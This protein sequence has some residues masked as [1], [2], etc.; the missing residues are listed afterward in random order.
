MRSLLIFIGISTLFAAIQVGAGRCVPGQSN[1]MLVRVAAEHR[2]HA[3]THVYG[4][5][6]NQGDSDNVI[7]K[8]NDVITEASPAVAS[9]AADR[10]FLGAFV[11]LVIGTCLIK[12]GQCLGILPNLRAGSPKPGEMLGSCT[13]PSRAERPLYLV[14]A[15][16]QAEA[17]SH[18]PMQQSRAWAEG[19]R[20]YLSTTT[21]SSSSSSTSTNLKSV[22]KSDIVAAAAHLVTQPEFI[23]TVAAMPHEELLYMVALS[24]VGLKASILQAAVPDSAK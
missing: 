8:V 4:C 22:E 6:M 23:A 7:N 17:C 19:S 5:S 10:P 9:P 24:Y 18:A 12:Y 11:A 1:G 16:S 14:R 20:A 13:A 21:M 15:L 2:P 3:A